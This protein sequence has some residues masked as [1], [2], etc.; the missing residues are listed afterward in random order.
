MLFTLRHLSYENPFLTA[1]S[2]SVIADIHHISRQ[3]SFVDVP[4]PLAML[5]TLFRLNLPR[6]APNADPLFHGLRI[7]TELGDICESE[8]F[9]GHKKTIVEHTLNILLLPGLHCKGH[10]I[11]GHADSLVS[12]LS[13]PSSPPHTSSSSPALRIPGTSLSLPSPFHFQLHII[14]RLSFNEQGRVTH[15]RDFWDVR[16]LLG[17]V[18]GVSLVQWLGTRIAAIGLSSVSRLWAPEKPHLVLGDQSILPE[19]RDLERADSPPAY[20]SATKNALGLDGD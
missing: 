18:P 3:L 12:S 11:Q 6:F 9:D 16:D 1:N 7:W 15:H 4:R 14:T 5:C 13:S 19:T 20:V 8:S 2:R 17:L 10:R